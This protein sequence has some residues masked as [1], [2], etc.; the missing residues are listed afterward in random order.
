MN[1]QTKYWIIGI[2]VV[3]II[4]VA[5]FFISNN[6]ANNDNK[7]GNI[8]DNNNNG[9]TTGNNNNNNNANNNTN[10]NTSNNEKDKNLTS[11]L[12]EQEKIMSTMIEDMKNIPNTKDPALDYLHGMIPHHVSAIAMSNSLLKYGG[13]NQDIKQIAEEIVKAQTKE[14]ED[15]NKLIKEIEENPKVDETKETE[16]L[17]EYNK[18]IN[19]PKAHSSNQSTNPKSVDEAYTEGMIMH[20]QMAVDMSKIILKYTDNEK[21]TKLAQDII[22]AQEK[23]IKYM[24]QI[25]E[26]LKVTKNPKA[27]SFRI[28]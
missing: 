6:M 27:K 25:L 24:E 18:L 17:E 5:W 13:E 20:H 2:V 19:D 23:E 1:N 14:I 8:T 15:M 26:T 16:Y 21:V 10:N 7:N 9:N 3:V 11:Y 12:E 4:I 28:F 22:E